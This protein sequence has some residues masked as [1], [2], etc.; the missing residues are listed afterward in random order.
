MP[1]WRW[2]ADRVEP[3]GDGKVRLWFEIDGAGLRSCVVDKWLT[4]PDNVARVGDA[5]AADYR[6]PPPRR[7]GDD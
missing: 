7:Y 2:I 4:D 1:D 3:Q 6:P 5:L